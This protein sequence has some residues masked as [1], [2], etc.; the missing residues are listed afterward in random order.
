MQKY[1]AGESIV[2]IGREECRNRETISRIVHSDEMQAFVR[3]MRERFYGLGGD[4]IDAVQDALR[5][6]KDGRLGFQLLMS[7]GVVPSPE[8]RQLLA[9]RQAAAETNED[10]EVKKIMESLV[11]SVVERG[12]ATGTPMPLL[13]E[14]QKVEKSGF[15]TIAAARRK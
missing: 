15:G 14:L 8:E 12:R 3:Q 13:E 9:A 1:V 2:Q 7:I 10:E 6:Q 4:A 11:W 5:E